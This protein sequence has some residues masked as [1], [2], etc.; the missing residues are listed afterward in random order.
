MRRYTIHIGSSEVGRG[1]VGVRESPDE[2]GA[3]RADDAGE[4]RARD[5]ADQIDVKCARVGGS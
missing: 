3:E 5:E 1:L 4:E 2:L